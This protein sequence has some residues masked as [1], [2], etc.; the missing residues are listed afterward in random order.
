[1]FIFLSAHRQKQGIPIVHV[2]AVAKILILNHNSLSLIKTPQ[3]LIIL[4]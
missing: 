3:P 4:L 1:M 2:D